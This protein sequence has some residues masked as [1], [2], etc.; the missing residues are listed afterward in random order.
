MANTLRSHENKL[1]AQA[2]TMSKRPNLTKRP[3]VTNV[4]IN[5]RKSNSLINVRRMP[6]ASMI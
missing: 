6:N 5:I 1:T 2:Q 3:N 4:I